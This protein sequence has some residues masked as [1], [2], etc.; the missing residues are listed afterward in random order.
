M[1]EESDDDDVD[2]PLES[3]VGDIFDK[4]KPVVGWKNDGEDEDDDTLRH[5][6]F[7]SSTSE[8]GGRC[9]R[10][11]GHALIRASISGDSDKMN[12]LCQRVSAWTNHL[13][14]V[15][16]DVCPH[17]TSHATRENLD[18]LARALTDA[19]PGLVDKAKRVHRGEINQ[20]EQLHR[21]GGEWDR[22][23]RKLKETLDGE[24]TFWD[25]ALTGLKR[26]VAAAA[27]AA[28][29]EEDT[30]SASSAGGRRIDA[31]TSKT[32]DI[33][34]SWIQVVNMCLTY[35]DAAQLSS[36]SARRR[37]PSDIDATTTTT[38]SPAKEA[39]RRDLRQ[40][41]KL[42]PR[43]TQQLTAA[44]SSEMEDRR[45]RGRRRR[46]RS[47]GGGNKNIHN[48]GFGF[49]SCC[50]EWSAGF[51]V[52]SKRVDEVLWC[53][54]E[55]LGELEAAVLA[56]DPAKT[57]SRLAK[58]R[59]RNDKY[60]GMVLAVVEEAEAEAEED[61]DELER[62][63]D[64][65]L[66]SPARTQA[67]V[68]AGKMDHL[69]KEIKLLSAAVGDVVKTVMTGAGYRRRDYH[70]DDDDGDD[71]DGENRG[72]AT[73]QLATMTMTTTHLKTMAPLIQKMAILLRAMAA[74][75]AALAVELDAHVEEATPPVDQL[76][77]II[78]ALMGKLV[79]DQ[80]FQNID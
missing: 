73:T 16:D 50:R 6:P 34:Q 56:R 21:I 70:H 48:D 65:S 8:G 13:T 55:L 64:G 46:R 49:S 17:V 3:S 74:K 40:H 80:Y 26:A 37:G 61:D 24:L 12:L 29:E 41:L 58:M 1:K 44:A 43:L 36:S 42:L 20:L 60:E 31:E 7:L 28:G 33:G 52:M 69:G 63:A 78:F 14:E 38:S 62:S 19:A 72:G 71:N 67:S 30:V 18:A 23:A 76:L 15:A 11:L 57:N 25:A 10:S 5:L 77:G 2:A 79:D 54:M 59:Q 66:A 27:A 4:T 75:T 53:E 9:R 68:A 45:H 51:F 35:L 32:K 22:Q 39:L 47:A